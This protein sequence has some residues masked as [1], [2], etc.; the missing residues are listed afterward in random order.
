MWGF[1]QAPAKSSVPIMASKRHVNLSCI[2][3]P[4]SLPSS[5]LSTS[6]KSNNLIVT[7][8]ADLVQEGLCFPLWVCGLVF[9]HGQGKGFHL[10]VCSDFVSAA[11]PCSFTV[12]CV[13]TS[14]VG[15]CPTA[16]VGGA[17]VMA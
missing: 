2:S 17:G 8:W 11:K 16:S 3:H 5:A 15:G 6:A 12:C 13:P 9:L 1:H 4:F 10:G 7:T 14:P